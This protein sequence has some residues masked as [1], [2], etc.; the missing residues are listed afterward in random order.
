MGKFQLDYKGMKD[1]E[2]FHDKHS[3]VVS[4]KKARAQA[5]LKRVQEKV[6][7]GS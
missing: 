4:D 1:V 7:G 6:K 2:R 5:L 3:R